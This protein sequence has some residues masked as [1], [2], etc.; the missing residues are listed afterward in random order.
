MTSK[1]NLMFTDLK[2][3][4]Y[5]EVLLKYPTL[6]ANVFPV[7][8]I[9]R[10]VQPAANQPLIDGLENTHVDCLTVVHMAYR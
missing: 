3:C 1:I 7:R 5:S 10:A 9:A 8:P 6:K 2:H 4:I